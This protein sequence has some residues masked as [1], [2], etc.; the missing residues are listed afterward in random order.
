M[1]S[2]YEVIVKSNREDFY[3]TKRLIA[4]RVYTV[5]TRIHYEIVP[6][7]SLNKYLHYGVSGTD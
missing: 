1:T 5:C 4:Q 7:N 2:S 6:L 3:F